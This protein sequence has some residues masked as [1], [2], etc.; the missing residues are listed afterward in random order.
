MKGLN[1][2]L[3][4]L[5]NVLKIVLK[6]NFFK[7]LYFNLKSLPLK[8][9]IKLPIHFYGKVELA[10]ISGEFKIDN[11][12]ISFGMIVFGGKHEV[13]ISSNVPTRIYNSGKIVFNGK[14]NFA[15][16]INVMV[17]KYGELSIGDNFSIGSLSKIICFRKISIEKDVLIS[18]EVQIF[19][20][21]FH[22]IVSDE[23]ITDNCGEVLISDSVWIGSRCT[24]L[25]NTVLPINT[26]VGSDSL[27]TG[28]YLEKYGESILL[29]GLPA[30]LIKNNVSYLKDKKKETEL[31]NVFHTDKR[32]QQS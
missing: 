23:K 24:I 27:C 28:N 9:A 19:D 5:I 6:L 2:K 14:A 15:R 3:K 12:K 26:I 31:F 7:T 17:W 22:F 20:T 18:W 32:A 30:K 10:N 16:G 21:D 4:T 29:A 11:D 8:Q 25:K 13:V 1:R